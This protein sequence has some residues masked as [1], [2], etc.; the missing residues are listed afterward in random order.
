MT[1]AAPGVA[2]SSISL[3]LMLMV[4]TLSP[5]SAQFISSNLITGQ[6]QTK[7][8]QEARHTNIPDMDAQLPNAVR[9]KAAKV[10]ASDAD[11][12]LTTNGD[13]QSLLMDENPPEGVQSGKRRLLAD[14]E[15][16]AGTAAAVSEGGAAASLWQQNEAK[17][18]YA[19]I[20]NP[21]MPGR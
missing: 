6:T 4:I 3:M 10:K 9:P 16:K 14:G 15:A 21:K 7:Q 20:R 8:Q 12:F 2:C 13:I 19:I 17:G 11:L 5:S 1:R 18:R